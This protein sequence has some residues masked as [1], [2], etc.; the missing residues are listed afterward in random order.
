MA[1]RLKF[2]KKNTIIDIFFDFMT[3]FADFFI[4]LRQTPIFCY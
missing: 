4:I 1:L 2:K 3:V